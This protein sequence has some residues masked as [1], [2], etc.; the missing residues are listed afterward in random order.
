MVFPFNWR[1]RG[2]NGDLALYLLWIMVENAGTFINVPHPLGS[3]RMKPTELQL[4]WSY[5]PR[6]GQQAR[7][8]A[9]YQWCTASTVISSSNVLPTIQDKT[10]LRGSLPS[11]HEKQTL[12]GFGEE[13]PFSCQYFTTFS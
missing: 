12:I 10:C 13:N 1:N 2:G 7:H 3:S 5:L 11:R 6:H 4:E 9:A 8:C